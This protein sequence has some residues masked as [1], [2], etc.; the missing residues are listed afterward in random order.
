MNERTNRKATFIG[1]Y[2]RWNSFGPKT[3]K[4]NLIATLTHR[5]FKICS[6]SS[7][8]Q[9]QDTKTLV[10]KLQQLCNKFIRITFG[11]KRNY[12]I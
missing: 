12:N 8:Q 7:L 9:E 11:L 2:I 6:K 10:N 4:T 1:E 5:V 3:R